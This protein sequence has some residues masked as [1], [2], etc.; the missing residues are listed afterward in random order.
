MCATTKCIYTLRSK[1]VKGYGKHNYTT[2][3]YQGGITN[4][5]AIGQSVTPVKG[6]KFHLDL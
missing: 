1:P 4:L 5:G 3:V 2:N 6:A